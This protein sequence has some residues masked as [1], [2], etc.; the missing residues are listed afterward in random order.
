[1]AG[2][3]FYALGSPAPQGS[4]KHVGHGVMIESSKAVKPWR[5]AVK[6]AAPAIDRPL[7]GPIV[8]RMV[9]TVARPKS[10]KK[11]E[12]APYRTPDLSKL[13]R[14]TEDAITDAGLWADDAR[15]SEY[16][17]L[18]KVWYP[19]D[20]LA[21]P[22]PGVI[23]VAMEMTGSCSWDVDLE[24]TAAAVCDQAAQRIRGAA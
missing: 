15:V 7:D 23:V 11:T 4:K 1:V 14:A 18:A 13:C 21:L 10:A 6:A 12:T 8:V 9:F 16:F 3:A 24:I 19:Y 5:E 17:G 20:P 22:T 2:F